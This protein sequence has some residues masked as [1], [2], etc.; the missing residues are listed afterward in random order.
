MFWGK[1]RFLDANCFASSLKGKI[2]M[3]LL[4]F[5][6]LTLKITTFKQVGKLCKCKYKQNG[7]VIS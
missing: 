7:L 1:E 2:S 6:C 3:A 4:L 5:L